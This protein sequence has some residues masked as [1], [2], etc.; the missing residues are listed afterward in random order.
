MRPRP[1][2]PNAPFPTAFVSPWH[3]ENVCRLGIR[4]AEEKTELRHAPLNP[5]SL[6]IYHALA[7]AELQEPRLSGLRDSSLTQ[8]GVRRTSHQACHNLSA[9]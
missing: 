5:G 9:L 2:L 1:G 4:T 3:P 8:K 6:T 7:T